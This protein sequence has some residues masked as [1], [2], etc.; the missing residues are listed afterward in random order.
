[1][2]MTLISIISKKNRKKVYDAL[3]R[4]VHEMHATTIIIY[5]SHL[6]YI[7]LEAEK[8]DQHYVEIREKLQ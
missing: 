1:M 3:R 5:K 4:R 8:S 7:V 6:K 2:S